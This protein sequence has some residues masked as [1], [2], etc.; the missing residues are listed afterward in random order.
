MF[1]VHTIGANSDLEDTDSYYCLYCHI[2]GFGRFFERDLTSE[3][4]DGIA[5]LFSAKG[6]VTNHIC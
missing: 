6:L 1:K 3:G 4:F 2:L 5:V